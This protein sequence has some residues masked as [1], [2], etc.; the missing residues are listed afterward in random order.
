[1]AETAYRAAIAA[2]LEHSILPVEKQAVLVD[3][4]LRCDDE[5]HDALA[6]LEGCDEVAEASDAAKNG[7]NVAMVSLDDGTAGQTIP[8]T[9]KKCLATAQSSASASA[10]AA[11]RTSS[12]SGRQKDWL[13]Q[14]ETSISEE[15]HAAG[16]FAPDLRDGNVTP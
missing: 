14:V 7:S 1:M 9:G 11:I 15:L 5:L 10:A 2:D 6:R 3:R 13:A 4:L 8:T 12:S 16:T